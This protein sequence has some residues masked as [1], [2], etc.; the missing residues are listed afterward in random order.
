MVNVNKLV[1][2]PS[3]RKE[4]LL[5]FKT[6]KEPEVTVRARARVRVRT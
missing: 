3:A 6:E 2:V 1:F 5:C 4:V